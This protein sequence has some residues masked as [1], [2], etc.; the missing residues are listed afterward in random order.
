M[1]YFL[2]PFAVH[3]LRFVVERRFKTLAV[4]SF[5]S[6]SPAARSNTGARRATSIRIPPR[7]P[8]SD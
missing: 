3:R 4:A 7:P 5:V 8:N 6:G 2:S 1:K